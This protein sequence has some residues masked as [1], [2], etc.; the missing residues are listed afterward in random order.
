LGEHALHVGQRPAG[1]AQG[2]ERV[3][4]QVGDFLRGSGEVSICAGGDELGDFF[5]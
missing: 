4:Q 3:V 5:A 1:S 2:Y